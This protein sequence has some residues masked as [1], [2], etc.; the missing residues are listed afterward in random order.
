MGFYGTRSFIRCS[1]K[2]VIKPCSES[3]RS[4][5]SQVGCIVY[6]DKRLKRCVCRRPT[7]VGLTVKAPVLH[8]FGVC[9]YNGAHYGGPSSRQGLSLIG[10]PSL[11]L[12][13]LILVA[14]LT[15]LLVA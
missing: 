14:H 8:L 7:L 6:A 12:C 5:P 11:F 10:F 1:P 3:C 15:M 13:G 4:G 9:D 2:F